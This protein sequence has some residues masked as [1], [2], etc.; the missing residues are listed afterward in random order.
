VATGE[1]YP[2]YFSDES[3]LTRTGSL[4]VP[5]QVGNDSNSQYMK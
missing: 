3:V 1:K 5:C 4:R 2:A